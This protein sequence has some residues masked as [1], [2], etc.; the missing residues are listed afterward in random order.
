MRT[1]AE[2][3]EIVRALASPLGTERLP[4][5]EAEGRVLAS[6]VVAKLPVP[7]FTNSAMDGYAVRAS[8]VLEGPVVLE[9]V[10]D[11]PAGA[12]SVP[13]VGEGQAA[14]IMTGAPMPPSAD[15]VVPVEATDQPRG[16]APLPQRVE[17]REP[18]DVRQ[19]VRLRG[20]NVL[21]GDPVMAAGS[22]LT[23]AALAS[24]ASVGYGEVDV[25]VRPRVAVIATGDELVAAGQEPGFGQVPDSNTYL[26]AGLARRFGAEVV[27]TH[28]AGDDPGA[29]RRILDE[30]A[31]QADVVVT[32]G[33]VSVGAFDVVRTALTEAEYEPVAMQ[34]GKPQASGRITTPDGRTIVFLG[35]PGNPVS[36]FVSGWAFLREVLGAMTGR[37]IPWRKLRLPAS[38]GWKS[39]AG[40]QQFIPVVVGEDGVVP[41]HEKGSGSHLIASLVLAD[42]LAVVPAETTDVAAGDTVDVY[43]VD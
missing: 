16:E 37:H 1:V 27:G 10:G 41:A 31:Q 19:N 34:P 17:V 18:V 36:V 20:G 24:L 40:R 35:L 12:S 22:V 26:V 3:Q 15:A 25:Y 14:R 29:F 43:L 11:V 8:D 2:Q 39:P 13:D 42:G 6:D 28:R 38:W 30:A 4:L 23:P 21:P 9:V 5:A 33:G 32:T 7:P